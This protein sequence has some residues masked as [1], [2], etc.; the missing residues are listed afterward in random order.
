MMM[1]VMMMLVISAHSTVNIFSTILLM[2]VFYEICPSP[3]SPPPP[4]HTHC[5]PN[6]A[7]MGYK[8]LKISKIPNRYQISN[9]ILNY[10]NIPCNFK[11]LCATL[12]NSQAAVTSGLIDLQNH[13]GLPRRGCNCWG[14]CH[15]T[16]LY[17]TLRYF[18]PPLRYF[19]IFRQTRAFGA[20]FYYY[21]SSFR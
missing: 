19:T 11:L 12:P 20:G 5:L 21:F 4:T 8:S 1:M 3:P 7:C 15:F 10:S 14:V 6:P 13:D 18:T 2:T 9:K 17:A 16:L